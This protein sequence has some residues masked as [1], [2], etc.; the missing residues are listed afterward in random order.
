VKADD[1]KRDLFANWHMQYCVSRYLLQIE[2][3]NLDAAAQAAQGWGAKVI[4]M[5]ST[6]LMARYGND[7][8]Y[9]I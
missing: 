7:S 2:R 5:L 9:S 4:D 8:G 3:N 1:P 6:D